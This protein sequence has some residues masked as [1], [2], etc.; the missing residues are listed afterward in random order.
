[1]T[2]TILLSLKCYHRSRLGSA[3]IFWEFPHFFIFD[4]F[5]ISSGDFNLFSPPPPPISAALAIRMTT[6]VTAG[7]G[8]C[9]PLLNGGHALPIQPSSANTNFNHIITKKLDAVN[10]LFWDRLLQFI[11]NVQILAMSATIADRDA[12]CVTEAYHAWEQH[13]QLLPS[14]LQ[15]VVSA[16]MLRKFIGCTNSWSLWDKILN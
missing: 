2:N 3:Q 16:S 11:Q 14:L 15:S 1:M 5:F 10:Y 9:D 13:D 8:G 12:G 6:P 4:H 7:G